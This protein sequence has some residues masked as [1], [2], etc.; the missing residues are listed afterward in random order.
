M[1]AET[2]WEYGK[3]VA[4]KFVMIRKWSEALQRRKMWHGCTDNSCDGGV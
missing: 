3:M 4:V 2:P 1:D